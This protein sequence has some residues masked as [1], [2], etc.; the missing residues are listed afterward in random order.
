MP[1]RLDASA[2]LSDER[3]TRRAAQGDERAF[4][5]IFDRYHQDLYRFCLAILGNP[6]DAQDALQNTMV[7]VLRA[8][9]GEQR[10]IEL[11]PWLY[12]IAHN[13][14]VELLRRRRPTEELDPEAVAGGG[15]LAEDAESRERLR[16]L[17]ADL[18]QLP[19][20]QR[21]ALVMRELGG[22]DFEEIATALGTSPATARQTLYEAR[23]SLRQMDEGREMK[24]E[25]VTRA[26]S[27]ADG[28]VTRRR[29]IRAHLRACP[30]CRRFQGEIA[31]RREDLGALAP[32]PGV[33]AAG[34]LQGV[35]GGVGGS[36]SAG[37]G[38]AGAAAGGAA[39]ALGAGTAI[40][41]TAAV[42]AVAVVGVGAADRGGVVDVAPWGGGSQTQREG[43]GGDGPGV[44]PVKSEAP[45]PNAARDDQGPA[46]VGPAAA[47]DA[48]APAQGKGGG[49]GV[50]EAGTGARGGDPFAAAPGS[51]ESHP[52][53]RGHEKQHPE[54][55]SH[56]QQTAA[57]HKATGNGGGN[58]GGGADQG[59]PAKQGKPPKPSK[60]SKPVKPTKPSQPGKQSPA[61]PSDGGAVVAPPKAPS[62]PGAAQPPHPSPSPQGEAKGN[63][64]LSAP[65]ASLDG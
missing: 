51:E 22:L 38:G 58:R 5:A 42:V 35:I 6:A 12:R 20:R 7:K 47:L 63:S 2:L 64:H 30:D 40:K 11:K 21:G 34:L 23:Q 27:D 24:C 62:G 10:R 50:T 4:A 55:A 8:L 60:P 54:A 33:A 43:T 13:E 28:R 45:G 52:H 37:A 39:K 29:D 65:A 46:A 32:L 18:G 44:A 49:Q 59:K 19:E 17:I 9:P 14:A 1:G 25:A 57:T 26:L 56:G 36:A 31:G 48:S 16:R 61:A 3:L 53:G 41:S 15:G